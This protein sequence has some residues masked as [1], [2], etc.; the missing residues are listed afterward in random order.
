MQFQS[1]TAVA[2]SVLATNI[3]LELIILVKLVKKLHIYVHCSRS[4]GFPLTQL[5]LENLLYSEHGESLKFGKYVF[6]KREN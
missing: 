1:T 6:K 2:I 5:S 4:Y 3:Y